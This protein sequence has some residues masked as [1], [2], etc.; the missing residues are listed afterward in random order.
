MVVPYDEIIKFMKN[1]IS[2]PFI[3]QNSNWVA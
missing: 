2:P 1:S 3:T